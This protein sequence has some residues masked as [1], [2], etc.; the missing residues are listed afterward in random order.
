MPVIV[1]ADGQQTQITIPSGSTVVEALQA[2]HVELSKLDRVEPPLY[3]KLSDGI[4]V[5]VI[6][7]VEELYTKEI[8]L[9][10]EHQE[11][12]NE[13]L[14]EG[15][16]RLSQP[17]ENGL[18]EITYRREIEDGIEVI[19]EPIKTVIIK[20]AVP[21]VM[22]V[23]TNSSFTALNI[24]GKIAYLS[25]GNAW[26]ME[27][28]TRNRFCA[29]STGDLDGRIFTLS[30][31]GT[32]LLFTRFTDE[33]NQINNL[34]MADLSANP[35]RLIDLKIRNVVHYAEFSGDSSQVAYSTAEWREAAPGW[36]ANNDLFTLDIAG[37]NTSGLTEQTVG[38]NSGG[39]YGWWGTQYAWSPDQVQFLFAQPDA[40][41]LI[42]E[43]SGS[44]TRLLS[45]LPYQTNGD[46]AWVPG[47]AWSPDG[48][49]V[50]TINH[51]LSG[52]ETN[53]ESQQFDLL[54][55]PLTGGSPISLVEDVGMFAYPVVSPVIRTANVYDDESGSNV[56]Q[57]TFYV[58]YLQAI[59]PSV[60]E[61]SAYWLTV[62]DRD[63]SNQKNL[64]PP[65]D[66]TGLEPQQV[67][68]SP[69]GVGIGGNYAIA[70][71]Y[72]GNIWIVDAETSAAQQITGDGLTSRVDWR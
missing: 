43:Q 48:Q 8:H 51:I 15:E 69:A 22:M 50:Y 17:G 36:Q 30:R 56:E 31:N 37:E 41:G 57:D 45:I 9:P 59:D 19:N 71:I 25:A 72:N 54:G 11:L 18:S 34:W 20:E 61:R 38:V 62:M 32:Y 66:T 1:A 21:E 6:R 67:A 7:V 14:P 2:A 39:V 46:W 16:K 24:P 44:Q 28:S 65:Q 49:V 29:V 55:I 13:A 64:F 53:G 33:A 3:S 35:I 58:A 12:K 63:G 4:N 52:G 26:I 70:V 40:I 47:V 68:W 5:K 60:S 27:V 23:G 42:D 10:F